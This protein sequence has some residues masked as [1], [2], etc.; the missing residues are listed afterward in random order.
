MNLGWSG[1][2]G[3]GR[4]EAEVLTDPAELQEAL[5]AMMEADSEFS[6]KVEGT[7]T[8][9]YASHI[10]SLDPA[11]GHFILHLVRPLPHELLSG[12]VFQML[13]T[14][15]EQRYEG[16]ITFVGR[17]AY[18]QYR[19]AL[20]VRVR[21]AD[22]RSQVR[23]PFR[24]RES[25][26]VI[27]ADG[28]FPSVG[29]AGPLVNIGLGGLAMRVDRVLQLDTGLRIPPNTALF[30]RGLSFPRIRI[31]DLP[32]LPFLE[33]HGRVAHATERGSEVLLGFAFGDLSEDLLVQLSDSLTYRE[34]IFRS[35]GRAALRTSDGSNDEAPRAPS[36]SKPQASSADEGAHDLPGLS[37][38]ESQSTDPLVILQRRM[39]RIL[40]VAQNPDLVRRFR[41]VVQL[42]GYVRL[43]V[44][45]GLKACCETLLSEDSKRVGLVIVDLALADIGDAE[46]LA[47]VRLIEQH[48]NAF[49]DTPRAVLCEAVDPTLL[50][51]QSSNT[52]FLSHGDAADQLWIETLDHF[53]DIEKGAMTSE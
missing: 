51:S 10:Q 17:E 52:R 35:S 13:F 5:H 15:E 28:R 25:A 18:L 41:M 42:G 19:F 27:A 22:R 12:A 34:R 40:L 1:K 14:V 6:I 43:E 48:L 38:G 37:G 21:Y 9:P 3:K 8:L 20:P 47:G 50:L 4:E 29:V 30:E 33:L 36:E 24:P 16:L 53:L 26:Y 11:V 46:P 32:R 23:H 7:S 44:V 39:K 49:P 31:Q 2:P 45:E